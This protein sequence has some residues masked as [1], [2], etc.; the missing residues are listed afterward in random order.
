V[1]Y[2]IFD[3]GGHV[4]STAIKPA[5]R[6]RGFGRILFMHALASVEKTLWLEV[7]SKN[8][9]AIAFY[10]KMGMTIIGRVPNY[11]GNDD[12]LVMVVS[13]NG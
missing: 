1:G 9:E 11:Y 7:R 4:H 12:A 13:Q 2:I 3:A 8:V 6:R 10:K 5:Y